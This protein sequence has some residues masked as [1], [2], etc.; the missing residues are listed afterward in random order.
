MPNGSGAV[1]R[2]RNV[3]E[4]IVSARVSS[5]VVTS[6]FSD[7]VNAFINDHLN[8]NPE[9]AKFIAKEMNML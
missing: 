5:A 1:H 6:R 2:C 3:S 4:L 8:A 7:K 9:Q